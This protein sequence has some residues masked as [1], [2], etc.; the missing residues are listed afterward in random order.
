M[1][2]DMPVFASDVAD[3]RTEFVAR[4]IGPTEA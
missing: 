3:D 4:H 2:G 1:Q